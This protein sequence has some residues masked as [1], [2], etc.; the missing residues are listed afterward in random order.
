MG[1]FLFLSFR[2]LTILKVINLLNRKAAMTSQS[3]HAANFP[4][5]FPSAQ[6]LNA[7]PQERCGSAD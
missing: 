3:A 7:Y 2:I 5:L 6:S 4:P 1:E